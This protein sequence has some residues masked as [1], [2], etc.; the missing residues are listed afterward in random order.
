MLTVY[1]LSHPSPHESRDL[2][3]LCRWTGSLPAVVCWSLS[4]PHHGTQLG[5]VLEICPGKRLCLYIWRG[6]QPT[7]GFLPGEF[8][9]QRSLVDYSPWSCKESDTTEQ[10][11]FF[12]PN[13][14]SFHILFLKFFNN[15]FLRFYWV[16]EID[17]TQKL[18]QIF[19]HSEIFIEYPPHDWQMS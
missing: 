6:W 7:P 9:G 17:Y 2:C 5:K 10:L 16:L 11:T 1:I 18:F 15:Q 12:Y 13:S 8:H 4:G 19:I 14:D 3:P